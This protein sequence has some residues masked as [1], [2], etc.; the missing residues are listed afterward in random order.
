MFPLVFQPHPQ[1]S[2]GPRRSSPSGDGATQRRLVARTVVEGQDH[3]GRERE[4]QD[5]EN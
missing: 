2:L 5:D 3:D 1:P 4:Y